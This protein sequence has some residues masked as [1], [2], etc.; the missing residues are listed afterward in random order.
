MVDPFRY[1]RPQEEERNV[2]DP[3]GLFV[4]PAPAPPAGS[5]KNLSLSRQEASATVELQQPGVVLFK[6]TYHPGWRAALD[7]AAVPTIVLTPGLLGVA[8][9]AGVHTLQLTY[10]SGWLK[11]ALLLVGV[12]F[13]VAIDRVP[14]AQP[15]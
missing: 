10:R 2:F 13:A 4:Q 3:P 6:V 1:R 14:A 7:G 8:V 12:L 15:R 11:V 5:I 9:P